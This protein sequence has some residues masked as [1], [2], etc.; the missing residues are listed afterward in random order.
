MLTRLFYLSAIWLILAFVMLMLLGTR[1]RRGNFIVSLF[2]LVLVIGVGDALALRL[3]GN[4][5]EIFY[6]SIVVFWVG[7][8]FIVAV[9]N[10]NALGQTFFL[11]SLLTTSL[12]LF[13]AFAI[14]AFSPLSPLAFIFSFFLLLLEIT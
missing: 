14:T 3:F 8:P 9:R 1:V 7:I 12:Y 13:Y 2:Y 5:F 4:L 11:C 10:W 6:A